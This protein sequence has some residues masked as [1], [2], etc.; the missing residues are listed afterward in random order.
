MVNRIL[1]LTPRYKN[2]SSESSSFGYFLQQYRFSVQIDGYR[3]LQLYEICM[4][5]RES[6]FQSLKAKLT[7]THHKLLL[8]NDYLTFLHEL[9]KYISLTP[10]KLKTTQAESVPSKICSVM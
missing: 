9:N 6:M 1:T 8:I 7:E 4:M 5:N 2:S 3:S 10:T